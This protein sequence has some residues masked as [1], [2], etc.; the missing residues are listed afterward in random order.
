MMSFSELGS[1]LGRPGIAMALLMLGACV[2]S[3]DEA[4]VVV[5]AGPIDEVQVVAKDA[6]VEFVGGR[7]SDEI[8]VIATRTYSRHRP[9]V[10][11]VSTEGQLHVS[12]DCRR[13]R[14]CEVHYSILLPQELDVSVVSDGGSVLATGLSGNLS[15]S[16]VWGDVSGSALRSREADVTTDLGDVTLAFERSPERVSVA[17][18]EGHVTISV[19]DDEDYRLELETE[20]GETSLVALTNEP[21]AERSIG[22][23]TDGGDITIRGT[24]PVLEGEDGEDEEPSEEENGS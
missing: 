4:F 14:V 15:V 11:V 8:R 12:H 5:D 3:M 22:V 21:D 18:L 20:R 17:T 1:G 7:R 13:Q 6:T 23:T 9:A 10:K 16:T 2:E 19:P 24:P